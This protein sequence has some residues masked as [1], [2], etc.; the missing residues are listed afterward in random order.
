V[1]D[2]VLACSGDVPTMEAIAAAQLL[3][4]RLPDL[5]VRVVNV[6]DLMRMQ[7]PSHHPHGL[8]DLLFDAI[9]TRESPVIFAFHGYPSLIHQLAYRRTN[10]GNLHVRGFIE[11][12]TT[13]TPFDMLHLN[14]LDR[15]RLALDV[16]HRVRGLASRPG[17]AEIAD[18]WH[19]ARAA[20]RDYAY[21]HGEDPEWITGWRYDA[22]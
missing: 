22:G 19:A 3:R 5:A 14:D 20:A 18:E 15:Y 1:P 11:K 7:D 2:V 9:F 8:N 13:T 12:G 17:V 6:V 4:D 21:E 10:H 16:L